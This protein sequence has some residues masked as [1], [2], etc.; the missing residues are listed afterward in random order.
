MNSY[1]CLNEYSAT[2]T[3]YFIYI[4]LV[5]SENQ[6]SAAKTF[7]DKNK[8][9][10]YSQLGTGVLELAEAAE[11]LNDFFSP[12]MVKSLTSDGAVDM[13]FFF[14]FNPS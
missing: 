1:I 11:L 4:S 10:A 5:H 13:D 7:N 12:A 3:G 9:D 2:G 14:Y 6:E 8:F